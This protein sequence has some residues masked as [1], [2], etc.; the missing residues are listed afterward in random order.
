MPGGSTQAC[1]ALFR[2]LAHT[3]L[4]HDLRGSDRPRIFFGG[5]LAG[6]SCRRRT[7]L[8][9]AGPPSSPNGDSFRI[10]PSRRA[11][12]SP[13]WG[14][15]TVFGPPP[16]PAGAY[17]TPS[18]HLGTAAWPQATAN[19]PRPPRIDANFRELPSPPLP[20][21]LG[22]A[23][24]GGQLVLCLSPHGHSYPYTRYTLPHIYPL[25]SYA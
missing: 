3:R 8:P 6:P 21:H 16:A 20:S 12:L 5:E 18:P 14:L 23:L 10:E 2:P 24:K 1:V 9:A 7:R 4:D 25:R 22:Y 17:L 15:S 11:A 19:H 13:F